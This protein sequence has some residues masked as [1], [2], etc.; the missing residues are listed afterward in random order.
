MGCYERLWSARTKATESHQTEA[1]GY[2]GLCKGGL[3]DEVTTGIWAMECYI[4]VAFFPDV[5]RCFMI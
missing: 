5:A 4:S 2:R 1:R 3:V